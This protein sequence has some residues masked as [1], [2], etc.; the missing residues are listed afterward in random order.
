M[1]SETEWATLENNLGGSDYA[2][3]KL[4]ETDTDHW[5]SPNTGAVDQ[6]GFTALPAGIR[7]GIGEFLYL[8][9]HTL[10]WTTNLKCTSEKIVVKWIHPA[11]LYWDFRI[12]FSKQPVFALPDLVFI[13][14]YLKCTNSA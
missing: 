4:K 6:Y 10:F 1:P 7:N 2:G 13:V 11:E 14:F 12:S 5:E 8:G 9:N 3:R